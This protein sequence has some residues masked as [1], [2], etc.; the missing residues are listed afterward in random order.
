MKLRCDDA[1]RQVDNVFLGFPGWTFP[2]RARYSA[3]VVGAA[4]AVVVA[5]IELRLGVHSLEAFATILAA[6]TVAVTYGLMSLVSYD[7]PVR[8][9]PVILWHEVSA[10]RA[11]KP[12]QVTLS[13]KKVKVG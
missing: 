5:V 7:R 10:P 3:Y 2:W 1:I 11:P 4:V 13:T 9:L 6:V 12:V 8:V